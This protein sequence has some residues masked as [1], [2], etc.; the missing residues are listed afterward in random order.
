MIEVSSGIAREALLLVFFL[1]SG[2]LLIFVYDVLRI[3]RQ[4]IPHKIWVVAFEDILYWIGCALFIFI[5]LCRENEGMIR[6]FI[7]GAVLVGML[8]YNHLLSP[9]IV[10]GVVRFFRFLYRVMRRPVQF[11]V[12]WM[13]RP[14]RFVSRYM[15]RGFGKL[16][17]V[18][19]NCCKAVKMALCKL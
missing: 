5:M 3:I 11:C 14:V 10:D 15:I 1:A 19:K 13:L 18:L 12:H 8:L 4:L 6:G 16:R 9:H 7:M 17:K 2:G